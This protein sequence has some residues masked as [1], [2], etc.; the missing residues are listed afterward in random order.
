[1]NLPKVFK[2]NKFKSAIEASDKDLTVLILTKGILINEQPFYAYLRMKPSDLLK[3]VEVETKGIEYNLRDY[4][5][6]IESGSEAEPP[7]NVIDKMAKEYGF[8]PEYEIK[9]RQELEKLAKQNK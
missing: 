7:Q 8:D 3:F 2:T 4:G 9:L 5:E 6:I 1:M